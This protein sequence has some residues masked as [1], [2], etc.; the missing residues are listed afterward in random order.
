VAAQLAAPQEGLSSVSKVV[1]IG[2]RAQILAALSEQKS[3]RFSLLSR[4]ILCSEE[5]LRTTLEKN[6]GFLFQ[7]IEDLYISPVLLTILRRQMI[8]LRCPDLTTERS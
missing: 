5:V 8:C 4:V 7:V 2:V 3:E 6:G 1:L